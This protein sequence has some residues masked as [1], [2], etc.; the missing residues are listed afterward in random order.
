MGWISSDMIPRDE[1][2]RKLFKCGW[3]ELQVE[4][5]PQISSRPRIKQGAKL[6]IESTPL[7]LGDIT[8]KAFT[9]PTE[10]PE[11]SA[12]HTVTIEDLTLSVSDYNPPNN[13]GITP[14]VA[15]M[16]FSIK[17]ADSAGVSTTVSFPLTYDVRFISAHECCPPL[18]VV[19]HKPSDREKDEI[20]PTRP[21]PTYTRLPGH[22]LHNSYRYKNVS[23]DSLPSTPAPQSNL[24][25][26]PD[27]AQVSEIIVIDAR[28]NRDKETFARAWCA[29]VGCHAIIS[30][31]EPLM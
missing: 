12:T 22:P 19:S 1:S 5:V 11:S 21:V 15:S 2:T 9:L 24:L 13:N 27:A 26:G 16:S 20:Q 3:L 10:N 29:A 7:G 30:K 8:A 17:D 18:G 25:Q 31:R 6:A 28:G 14:A 23:L 4:E